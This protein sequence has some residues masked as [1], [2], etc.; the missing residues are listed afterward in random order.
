M[1]GRQA[2]EKGK[3]TRSI[4]LSKHTLSLRNRSGLPGGNRLDINNNHN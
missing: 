4:R 1:E 2:G 3:E